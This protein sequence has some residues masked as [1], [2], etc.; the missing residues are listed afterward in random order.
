MN[1]VKVSL[2]ILWV[3]L[4]ILILYLSESRITNL[5]SMKDISSLIAFT[6]LGMLIISMPAGFVSFLFVIILSFLLDLFK[7]I[8]DGGLIINKHITLLVVWLIFLY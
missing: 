8:P 7:I 2:K 5:N 1:I 3:S 4:S 6:A